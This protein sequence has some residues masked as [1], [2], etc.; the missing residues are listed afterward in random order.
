MRLKILLLSSIILIYACSEKHKIQR[1]VKE[2]YKLRKTWQFFKLDHPI[3]GIVLVHAKGN[4]GYANIPSTSLI[5]T[6]AHDSIRIIEP[7]YNIVV[8]ANDSVSVTPLK[9]TLGYGI[10]S[11]SQ[12]EYK[13]KKT[14]YGVVAKIK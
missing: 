14:C 13:I 9:D 1:Q 2:I 11:L 4:C 7:C 6:D 5:V 10:F 8:A 12:Y 3:K